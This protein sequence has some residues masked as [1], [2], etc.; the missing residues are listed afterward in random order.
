MER[1][2][3]ERLTGVEERSKAR[4]DK[5][6][7]LMAKQN[8]GLESNLTKLMQSTIANNMKALGKKGKGS[9]KLAKKG[10]IKE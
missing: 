1:K 7:K 3:A 2:N 4:D 5:L 9:T 10:T 6:E 8:A